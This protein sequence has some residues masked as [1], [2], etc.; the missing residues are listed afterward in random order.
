ML[1]SHPW[2]LLKTDKYLAKHLDVINTPT[3][4]SHEIRTDIAQEW[5][6]IYIYVY[7]FYIN[8]KI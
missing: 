8:I 7:F 5:K 2:L 4:N 6:N 1:D 3:P